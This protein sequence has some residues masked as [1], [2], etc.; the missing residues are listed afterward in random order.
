[1]R[2]VVKDQTFCRDTLWTGAGMSHME[3]AATAAT[4]LE[5]QVALSHCRDELWKCLQADY[6][7]EASA[8]ALL[9]AGGE[10]G[11]A[12]PETGTGEKR[13]PASRNP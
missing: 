3:G 2:C 8:Y 10:P 12:A 6:P 5:L 4:Q 13:S 1:M 9:A 11:G 7:A